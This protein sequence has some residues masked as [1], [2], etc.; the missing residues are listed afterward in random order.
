MLEEAHQIPRTS[1]PN[2]HIDRRP[3]T[4]H[5]SKFRP[6][7]PQESI[8]SNQ[9]KPFDR[10]RFTIGKFDLPD[11]LPP[12][13][14]KDF[15]QDYLKGGHEAL[16]ESDNKRLGRL[17]QSL[18]LN[19][20]MRGGFSKKER[21]HFDEECKSVQEYLDE[22]EKN[23]I[24][25]FDLTIDCF[26]EQFIRE[27][28]EE[29]LHFSEKKFKYEGPS[30]FDEFSKFLNNYL[31]EFR[32]KLPHFYQELL[33]SD[34]IRQAINF[35]IRA[36]KEEIGKR[37]DSFSQGLLCKIIDRLGSINQGALKDYADYLELVS[38]N[39]TVGPIILRIL[40]GQETLDLLKS[41]NIPEEFLEKL[42]KIGYW[43]IE[44]EKSKIKI[45]HHCKR[46]WREKLRNKSKTINKI[47]AAETLNSLIPRGQP[48]LKIHINEKDVFEEFSKN[49]DQSKELQDELNPKKV[50]SQLVYLK[51]I[52]E[53]GREAGLSF[54]NVEYQI[55]R[56]LSGLNS[57]YLF[58]LK[59]FT[60]DALILSL[61]TAL[62]D[63]FPF[64]FSYESREER[65]NSSLIYYTCEE[66]GSPEDDLNC[67]MNI[68]TKKKFSIKRELRCYSTYIK[69]DALSH[70]M[71]DISIKAIQT[72]YSWTFK[73]HKKKKGISWK[74]FLELEEIKIQNGIPLSILIIIFEDMKRALDI[75][76]EQ[77]PLLRPF[78]SSEKAPSTK[79][80][81]KKDNIRK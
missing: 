76:E 51:T 4:V 38:S 55:T 13:N 40:G 7:T 28:I 8:Y 33:D 70:G 15:P 69:K 16:V 68:E 25:S 32:L 20:R 31:E 1:S 44:L 64:F 43:W 9:K 26:F 50:V 45:I 6:L 30:D 78:L 34:L 62:T 67:F 49:L 46:N 77:E 5:G 27:K 74:G 66:N 22:I 36:L 79:R 47:K 61:R 58:L 63:L 42:Y 72:Y 17:I 23:Q 57:P 81:E 73:A 75:K 39:K 71:G 52:F 53:L 19:T 29:N 41:I 56:I 18:G 37:L 60:D 80:K 65:D 54:P 10:K 14:L 59:G 21:R 12:V 2:N 35:R 11:D 24:F 48:L 3:A